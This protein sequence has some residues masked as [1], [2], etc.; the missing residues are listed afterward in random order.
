[1]DLK[2]FFC[3]I[4]FGFLSLLTSCGTKP[5]NP[6]NNYTF[7]V[8]IVNNTLFDLE[9]MD[10]SRI[11]PRLGEKTITLPSYFGELNDGYSVIYR[12]PFLGDTFLRIPRVENI[13]IRNDQRTAFIDSPDFQ[14]DLCFLILRNTGNQT[15]SLKD[16]NAYLNSVVSLDPKE[17]SSSLYLGPGNNGL[18]ELKPGQNSL[19][20]E[21]D[22]YRNIAFQL[23]YVE[24]GYIYT[25]IFDGAEAFPID[26]RPLAEIGQST[27]VVVE[28]VGFPLSQQ[29]KQI[30]TDGLRNAF[31]TWNNPLEPDIVSTA[32]YLFS[33]VIDV[34]HLPPTPPVN[35][36]LFQAG[37]ELLFSINGNVMCET[38]VFRITEFSEPLLIL[39]IAEQLKQE[40]DFYFRIN[41]TIKP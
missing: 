36:N 39:Q 25:F 7:D 27:K 22:Q 29:E 8:N 33:I 18:Y 38:D 19:S 41:K 34:T 15:V 13:I 31:Q 6:S 1:M 35:A 32:G 28:F 40:Q 30:I 5:P 26:A 24:S 17:Y 4:L 37:V 11:I 20:I 23:N 3:F 9:I 21:I 14:S 2:R 10:G 16:S 12:V